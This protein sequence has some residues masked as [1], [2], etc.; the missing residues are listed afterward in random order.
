MAYKDRARKEYINVRDYGLLGSPS[1]QITQAVLNK[2]FDAAVASKRPVFFPNGTY[3]FPSNFNYNFGMNDIIILGEDKTNTIIT[4]KFG[5]NTMRIPERIDIS[6]PKTQPDGFYRINVTGIVDPSWS[7]L[8]DP[9]ID[10]YVQISAGVASIVPLSTVK[11]AGYLTELDVTQ[12]DPGIDGK[13]VVATMD[14]TVSG[15][16]YTHSNLPYNTSIKYITGTI[17]TR[18]AG[19]WARYAPSKGF[20]FGG[21][22]VVENIQ[23]IDVDFY[24]FTPNNTTTPDFDRYVIK[25]C[26]FK[27]VPRVNSHDRQYQT[28]AIQSQGF[29]K[30]LNYHIFDGQRFNYNRIEFINN[31]FAYIHTCILWECP[32][33]KALTVKD[34]YIHDCYTHSE[35][36]I[37]LPMSNTTF[38]DPED[39]EGYTNK[40]QIVFENNIF[41]NIIHYSI[42]SVGGHHLMRG[43][44]RGKFINNRIINATG[45]FFYIS[46]NNNVIDG[47]IIIPYSQLYPSKEVGFTWGRPAIFHIKTGNQNEVASTLIV[48]NK[49]EKSGLID[50]IDIKNTNTFINV[51]NNKLQAFGYSEDILPVDAGKELNKEFLH[52]IKDISTFRTLMGGTFPT[53]AAGVYKT[54]DFVE[55][56]STL[57]QC[58]KRTS[59]ADLDPSADISTN[60]LNNA[61]W[62][63]INN[64]TYV[65]WD[66]RRKKWLYWPGTV[67][68]DS[69]LIDKNYDSD[70][71]FPILINN[72]TIYAYNIATCIDGT[73]ESLTLSNND[74]YISR[75]LISQSVGSGGYGSHINNLYLYNNRIYRGS[76]S[77][78]TKYYNSINTLVAIN[79]DF[80]YA[81]TTYDISFR[82]ECQ[83][84]NNRVKPWPKYANTN[85]IAALG[86]P[87]STCNTAVLFKRTMPANW[88][89]GN[90]STGQFATYNGQVYEAIVDIGPTDLDPAT[91]T[92]KWRLSDDPLLYIKDGMFDNYMARSGAFYWQN[93]NRVIIEGTVF[94]VRLINDWSSV[95]R[96][97][98][99]GGTSNRF[100]LWFPTANANPTRD[101]TINNV[102]FDFE[103]R[104]NR[105]LFYSAAVNAINFT[106]L[107]VSNIPAYGSYPINKLL[108]HVSGATTTI[109]KLT[110]VGADDIL[111]DANF[112]NSI[113]TK[114]F[115]NRAT[116]TVT[117]NTSYALPRGALVDTIIVKSTTNIS[118]FKIGTT[119]GGSEI[120][121]EALTANTNSIY[122]LDLY[123]DTATTIYFTGITGSSGTT[124]I[125]IFKR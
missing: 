20:E 77:A 67:G 89:A 36:F 14:S 116:L 1:T 45:S 51:A 13:Y 61:K 59:G 73:I 26:I 12:A 23:F 52:L 41:E 103:D 58:V 106:N 80:Y 19:V 72:N 9:D 29:V 65:Y 84:L 85:N 54:G 25:N 34:N 112:E 66:I 125:T 55:F 8:V 27:H 98:S 96:P 38:T 39:D 7:A 53:W 109:G 119:S 56:S 37:Y 117:A 47:N 92:T 46:G 93:L 123:A 40:T 63:A 115:Q 16:G 86:L 6:L 43:N 124:T 70:S 74:I 30:G 111:D 79:N 18:T 11:A 10:D 100:A 42:V 121:D 44:G 68:R 64:N 95:Y 108:Y 24:L 49:I 120:S 69:G 99:S 94:N 4:T 33:T 107:T 2:I 60:G 81:L 35:M 32:P 76:I 31:E 50:I 91:E 17:L 114:Q 122:H 110:T 101:V 118:S 88:A 3:V 78:S 102:K 105:Y 75:D 57:Y 97:V 21:N 90:Y 48:N 71:S 87:S 113:G 22:F 15:G 104:N 62:R 28:T 83:W 5:S 82:K